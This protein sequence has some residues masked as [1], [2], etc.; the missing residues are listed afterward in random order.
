MTKIN[1]SALPQE[2]LAALWSYTPDQLDTQRDQR[3]IIGAVLNYGTK[4]ATDWLL[5]YYGKSLVTREAQ[6]IPLG[7]WD[8]HSLALWSLVLGITPK[9]RQE[10]FK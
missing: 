5:E 7:M 3:L 4:S 6:H 9:P 1:K 8:K 10:Q 2:V